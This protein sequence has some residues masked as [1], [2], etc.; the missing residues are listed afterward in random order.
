MSFGTLTTV[1][2][3]PLKLNTSTTT[4]INTQ[5]RPPNTP[6]GYH[7]FYINKIENKYSLIYSPTPNRSFQTLENIIVNN[8]GAPVYS[9]N[10]S[11]FF[12][13]KVS[14]SLGNDGFLLNNEFE[15]ENV[16]KQFMKDT[17]TKLKVD[18]IRISYFPDNPEGFFLVGYDY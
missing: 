10:L 3:T 14:K 4:I 12:N 9:E 2:N 6:S 15:D 13:F 1:L 16:A 8:S 7:T 5:S 18:I 17:T 11:K